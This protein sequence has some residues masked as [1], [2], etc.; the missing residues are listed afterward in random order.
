MVKCGSSSDGSGPGYYHAGVYC[1]EEEEE[2][3]HFT[4][5]TSQ[6]SSSGSTASSSFS[7]GP[8][9]VSKVHVN[10]FCGTNKFAIYR[11]NGEIP[12]S[13]RANVRNA[14]KKIPEY[15]VLD[16]NCIHFA[17]GLLDAKLQVIHSLLTS[18][19]N[20]FET[21]FHDHDT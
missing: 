4:V 16:Y 3:I 13:F 10:M 6:S 14:M 19:K 18:E 11:K 5:S 21:Y 12:T 8:G 20:D 17:M 7:S 2:I 1:S 15:D 9:F